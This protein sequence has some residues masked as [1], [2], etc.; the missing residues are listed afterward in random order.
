VREQSI[1]A[2]PPGGPDECGPRVDTVIIGAGIAGCAAAYYLAKRG[3]RV[4]LFDKGASGLEQSTRNWGWVHSQIRHLHLI[5]L[6]QLALQLWPSLEAELGH[7]LSWRQ[8]GSITLASSTD[9]LGEL[10]EWRA[11]ALALGL[12]AEI[13][14]PARI[15]RLVPGMSDRWAGAL[16]IPIDGQA[17]PGNA[18]AAFLNAAMRLGVVLHERC[19]VIGLDVVG[20]RVQG[21][22]TER[23]RFRADNIVCAA[24][25]WSSRLLR[26]LGV[27]VPQR[28]LRCT[29]V[30]TAPTSAISRTTIASDGVSVRQ[31][32]QGR[33]VLGGGGIA[34]YD[35]DCEVFNDLRHFLKPSWINRKWIRLA[36]GRR[37]VDDVRAHIPGSSAKT[38][39]WQDRRAV[40]PEPHRGTAR[41]N[42]EAFRRL[43]PGHADLEVEATWA[44]MLDMTP[45]YAPLVG[46]VVDIAGLYLNTGFSGHGFTLAPGAG[47]LLSE[48]IMGAAPS[49]DPRQY[50]FARFKEN[51]LPAVRWGR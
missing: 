30:R 46:P 44:G 27:H 3:Q 31:D 1:S 20:G 18:T 42:L 36:L 6:A 43:F 35:I 2:T 51:D 17:D 19:A 9:R 4:V 29:V 12:A 15:E 32:H 48:L 40:E 24:G 16:Y 7:D 23:G 41:V 25:S 39:F 14:P 34:V 45:D 37:L 8:D 50:R 49:I 21:V 38:S 5:P 26:P 10:E 47:K 11:D 22:F 13:V 33:F 28:S